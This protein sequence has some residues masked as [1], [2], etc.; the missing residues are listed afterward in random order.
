MLESEVINKW[1]HGKAGDWFSRGEF[2]GYF[3]RNAHFFVFFIQLIYRCPLWNIY[4]LTGKQAKWKTWK[5]PHSDEST[6]TTAPGSPGDCM[7]DWVSISGKEKSCQPQAINE[8]QKPTTMP[9]TKKGWV[10][11]IMTES[12]HSQDRWAR[13]NNQNLAWKLRSLLDFYFKSSF[14]NCWS[15]VDLQCCVNFCCIAK[16]YNI[17]ILFH[18]GLSQDIEYSPLCYIVDLIIYSI[19]NISS[20][21]LLIPNSQSFPS[22]PPLPPATTILF[23][24]SVSLFMFHR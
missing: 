17:H 9:W 3:S 8:G 10:G 13:Q 11:W 15:I 23:S 7:G 22:P 12:R 4:S 20:L 2:P 6:K 19:Y 24:M 21:H 16:L 5:K 18:Y 14:F 1:A